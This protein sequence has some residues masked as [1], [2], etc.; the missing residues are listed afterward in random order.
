MSDLSK[1]IP[2]PV[3][4]AVNSIFGVGLQ[5]MLNA[6]MALMS[7]MAVESAQKAL[8]TGH[9]NTVEQAIADLHGAA[10][11]PAPI[12]A[13]GLEPASLSLGV[14]MQPKSAE[15]GPTIMTADQLAAFAS[16]S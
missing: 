6:F 14:G 8:I 4:N 11:A 13:P 10:N 7:E 9:V 1:A 5:A 12:A 15:A 2:A 16:Q 3:K